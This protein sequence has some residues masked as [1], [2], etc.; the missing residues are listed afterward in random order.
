MDEEVK[1]NLRKQAFAWLKD[2]LDAWA[3]YA[4]RAKPLGPSMAASA[5]RDWLNVSEL[6][7]VRDTSA[8]TKLPEAERMEWQ[9]LWKSVQSLSLVDPL[10][11]LGQ[12]R[13]HVARKQWNQAGENYAQFIQQSSTTDGEVWF[14]YAAVQLLSGDIAG[15]RA[16]CRKLVAG[17]PQAPKIRPYLVTR[18]STLAPNTSAHIAQVTEL[19]FPELQGNA[20]GFWSLTERGAL[21]CRAGQCKE[22]LPSF[23]RSLQA[24]PRSGAAVLNWL[25]LAL[26]HHKLNDQHE[27]KRWLMKATAFL[28]PL[29]RGLSRFFLETESCSPSTEVKESRNVT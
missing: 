15:Y 10:P 2:D 11:T 7:S 1:S 4:Q 27:A 29:D 16:T 6:A 21:E 25:W 13:A 20:L 22:S 28:D 9:S 8:L 19:S 26:A 23:E 24:E 12:A 18:A 14:E 5:M 17:P 3:K